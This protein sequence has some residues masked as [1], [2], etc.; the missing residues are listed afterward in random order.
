MRI[1]ISK[2]ATSLLSHPVDDSLGFCEGMTDD[3]GSLQGLWNY[4]FRK[5]SHGNS[6]SKKL[7]ENLAF[8]ENLQSARLFTVY[9]SMLLVLCS[10]T[11]LCFNC[12]F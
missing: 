1:K 9:I 6:F 10:L 3:D 12:C 11:R 7:R 8:A 2:L 5:L 4:N